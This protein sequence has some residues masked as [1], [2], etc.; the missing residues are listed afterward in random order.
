MMHSD[1]VIE[2]RPMNSVILNHQK[3]E[4]I[5]RIQAQKIA[6]IAIIELIAIA[7]TSNR[8]VIYITVSEITQGE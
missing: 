7:P 2:F 1:S 3:S 6:T 4:C 5:E 8:N